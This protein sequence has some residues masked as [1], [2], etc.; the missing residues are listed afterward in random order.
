MAFSVHG[1]GETIST[2]GSLEGE[3]RVSSTCVIVQN[4]VNKFAFSLITKNLSTHL[5]TFH[6]YDVIN[7]LILELMWSVK[8]LE[9]SQN[10]C[11]NL[12][13][14]TTFLY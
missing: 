7:R 2:L 1:W 3:Q 6:V 5:Y 10:S 13:S 14:T 9:P 11:Y 12:T 4:F 8:N